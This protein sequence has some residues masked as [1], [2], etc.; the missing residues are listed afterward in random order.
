MSFLFP[1]EMQFRDAGMRGGCRLFRLT[2]FFQYVSSL[3]TITVPAGFVTDGA[4]IPQAFWSILGP[5]G[6]YFPA[7]LIH[8]YLYSDASTGFFNTTRK[9]SDDIFKEAMFN[10]GVAWPKRE[11]IYRAV[12]LFGGRNY[13]PR[14]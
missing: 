7:A 1:D 11:I 3:G 9:Q 10:I 4:S 5:H 14:H 8:D 2:H 6:E 12:R 13:K